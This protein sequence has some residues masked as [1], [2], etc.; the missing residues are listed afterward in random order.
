MTNPIEVIVQG[1]SMWPTFRNGDRLEFTA[2]AEPLTV[3]AVVLVHHPFKPDV[4]MV[5]RIQ[6]V[7]DNGRLFV[8]GDQ[9]DPTASE[10]S[11]NFGAVDPANVVGLWNGV[12]KRA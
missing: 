7:T 1:D 11:H 10:D 8:V 2:F 12:M 4:L 5:K 9:P 6:S 3:G